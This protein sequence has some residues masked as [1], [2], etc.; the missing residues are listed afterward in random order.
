MHNRLQALAA[1][2]TTSFIL[3]LF[4]GIQLK[5]AEPQPA[6]RFELLPLPEQ[7]LS[8]LMDG[9]EKT[10]WHFG[11]NYPR[12]FFYPFN[13]PSGVSLTRMGHPGAPNH[14]HHRSV[15]FAHYNINGINFWEEFG[16]GCIRQKMWLAYEDGPKESIMAVLLEW[17]DGDKTVVMGQEL[18]AALIDMPDG[19][20][21][22]EIQTT[23]RVP[24]GRDK[25]ELAKTNFGFLAVRVAKS[26]SGHFGD[27]T[28]SNSEGLTG[29]KSTF[30]KRARWMD[31]SG[32][33][34]VKNKSGRKSVLEGIT[35]YDH[36]S[37]PRYPSYW[38]VR[39]DG[40]MGASFGMHEKHTITKEKPLR[41]RYLLHAHSGSYDASKAQKV[42][43]AFSGRKGFEVTERTKPHCQFSVKRKSDNKQ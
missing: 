2:S 20:H 23:M 13:G 35:Y 15:W 34:T 32:S 6:P 21:A 10:K 36:P 19:E 1:F 12:P 38:H 16:E 22:L 9:V 18:I 27:G 8:F 3:C 31:Y 37:N 17:I 24:E 4:T 25:V 30:G 5:A 39:E 29:E 7:Q 28:I 14:D 26:I 42:H 11:K 33:V 43:A 41:L 40:W